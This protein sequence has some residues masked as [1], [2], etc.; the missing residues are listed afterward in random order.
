[1]YK[2]AKK[3]LIF[4]LY[5][6]QFEYETIK[7]ILNVQKN[8][9]SIIKEER[10]KSIFGPEFLYIFVE[11]YLCVHCGHGTQMIKLTI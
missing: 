10:K 5:E 11:I 9:N 3:L 1:M 7:I 4:F 2:N 6:F 8:D